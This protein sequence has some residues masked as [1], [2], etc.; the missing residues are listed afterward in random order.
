MAD[1]NLF[2]DVL[3]EVQSGQFDPSSTKPA[4]P[5]IFNETLGEVA[6]AVDRRRNLAVLAGTQAKPD[7]YATH[8]SI[9]EAFGVS[10]EFAA[11]NKAELEPKL[12]QRDLGE[13]LSANPP[14][15]DW[16]SQGDNPAS[17][18]VDELRQLDGLS[19]LWQSAVEAT[20]AGQQ[21]SELARL[22]QLQMN[23]DATPEQ[24]EQANQISIGREPRSFGADNWLQKGWVGAFQQAPLLAGSVVQGVRR[25]LE[26]GTAA[27]GVAA[28]AGQA[29]PQIAAPEELATVPGAYAGGF[30]VGTTFGA[31]E[32][33]FA[34]EAP[35]AFDEFLMMRDENG[36]PLDEDVARSAAL[37]AGLGSSVLET[38]AD[39]TLAKLIPGVDRLFGGTSRDAVKAALLQPT[40]RTALK[41]FATN[42]LKAGATEIT[43]EVAQEA[44]QIFVGEI[45]KQYA[46]TTGAE[47][48]AMEPDDIAARLGDAAV[49]TAQAMTI[50]GP[51]LAGT[52]LGV[53]LRRARE[54][55][56]S[57]Q[58]MEGLTAHAQGNQEALKRIPDK[59]RDAVATLTKDGPVQ[60]VY[61]SPEAFSTYFQTTEELST[62]MEEVGL[63][64]E[65]G[66][67][68]RL[69]RDIQIPVDLYYTKIAGSE[70]GEAV[71]KFARISQ[72]VMTSVEAD[73]FNEAW[74]EA[75]EALFAEYDATQQSERAA[76]E[77]E[78]RVFDDVKSKAMAAGITPDQAQQYAKLYSTFFRV[79]GERASIDP[80]ELFNRYGF[81]IKR[82]LP[83]ET[84]YRPINQTALDLAVI[85][86]GKVEGMRKKVAKAGGPSL[87]AAIKDVGGIEDVGGDLAAMDFPKRLIK[88]R[89]GTGDMLGGANEN[90]AHPDA[91]AKR[92]WERGYFAGRQD[93]PGGKDLLD[94]IQAELAGDPMFSFEHDR[95]GDA[96]IQAQAGLVAFADALD[97]YGIDVNSMTDEEVQAELDKITNADPSTGALF[98]FAGK[99]ARSIDNAMLTKAMEMLGPDNPNPRDPDEVF[100]ETGFFK[101]PDGKWRFEI[102]DADATLRT[103]ER[104]Q[105]GVGLRPIGN[106]KRAFFIGALGDILRHSHLEAAYPD[107]FEGINVNM[108]V[109]PI[110]TNRGSYMSGAEAITVNAKTAEEA[111]SILLHEVA[112]AIQAKES[113][114]NGGNLSMGELYEGEK[115]EAQKKLVERLDAQV[116]AAYSE[117]EEPEPSGPDAAAERERKLAL[118][119]S[120]GD[121]LY[122]AKQQLT[123][124]AQYEYYRRIAGEVEARNV[125]ERDKL[126][127]SDSESVRELGRDAPW[128]TQDVD[129]DQVII[130]RSDTH[131]EAFAALS[132][133]PAMTE[134]YQEVGVA[135]VAGKKS[136]KRGSIQFGEGVTIINMFDQA[137]LSTFLHE[138]GHFF[139][140]VFA[141]IANSDQADMAL[142]SDWAS[143]VEYLGVDE[144][145][146]IGVEA[147]EKFARSFEAYLFEGK[148]PSAELTDIMTRFRSWLVFVYKQVQALR[149]PIDDNIRGVMSRMLATDAE[150]KSMQTAPEFRPAFKSATDAG[151]TPEQWERYNVSAAKA[152]DRAKRELDV[153]M[154]AEVQRETSAEYRAAKTE[155]RKAVKAEYEAIPAYRV[156]A[157]LRTG[158]LDG[159]PEG[160]PA[161]KLDRA[162]IVKMMGEGALIRMP[163]GV[164]PLYRAEGGV[165]PDAIAELFGFKSGH[166]MLTA[167]MS[168]PN[169]GR[170]ITEEVS[171]RMRARFGDLMG[172]ANAR[173]REAEAA[174]AND[175]TGEL[176]QA[177]LEVLV[178]KGLVNTK[179]NKEAASRAAKRAIRAKP[180]REAIRLKLY[181]NANAKA[182]AEAEKAIL[183]GD[184][185]TAIAAKQR[186]LLNHYMAIEARE[187]QRVSDQ[188]V[189]YL[190]KFTGKKRPKGLAVDY[191]EQIDGLLERFDLRKSVGPAA[192]QRRIALSEWIAAQEAQ[193]LLVS[194]PD[195][196][197]NDAMRKPFRE[198][199]V[200]DLLALT[201]TVK[202]IE[203]LGRLKDKLLANKAAREFDAVRNEV[204]ASIM[205]N[206]ELGRVSP[207]Q[208]PTTGEKLLSTVKSV[209][210]GLLKIEQVLSWLD[211]GD[212]NGALRRHVWQPIAD[213]EAR[214]N[215]MRTTYTGKIFD[216]M[217]GLDKQRLRETLTIGG[218]GNLTRS[219]IMSVALNLGNADNRA[220]LMR[221]GNGKGPWTDADVSAIVQHLNKEEWDAVQNIWDTINELW[222]EIAALQKRLS[223]VAPPKVEAATVE[224]PYGTLKGG[225]YPVVYDPRRSAIV[226]DRAAEAASKLFE[227]TYLK[228][229]TAHGFT[230]ER[231]KGDGNPL[232]L[233]ID[234]AASH[235]IAVIHDLT[236][237]EAIMD[238]HKIM[239]DRTVRS[240]IEARYGREI[241]QQ[242]VPWLQSIA[243][244]NVK[245]DGLQG[246]ETVM[247]GVRSRATMVGMGFRVTTILTQVAGFSSVMEMVSP[248]YLA[249]G[250]GQ[251]IKSPRALSAQINSMSSE[252][253][254]RGKSLDRDVRDELRRLSG[255]NGLADDAKRFAFHGIAF[256]DRVVTVPAWLGAYT[257]HLA[258]YPGDVEG[259]TAFADQVVRLTSGAGGAKDLAA[260]QR[261]N[262]GTKLITMFY[263]YFSAYYNRQRTWGRAAKKAIQNGTFSDVPSL[264][265]QQVFMTIGPAVLAD[266]IVGQ[267]PGEDEDY[268]SWVAKKVALYPFMAL[269]L[270]R[271]AISAL[272]SGF[273]YTFTPAGRTVQESILDPI[274][275]IAKIAEG[276]ATARETVVQAI[277]TT[278]YVFN[279]PLGQLATTTNNVWKAIEEDDLQLRDFVVSR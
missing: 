106:T 64:A 191:L 195:A 68:S 58:I 56:R 38:F 27:A 75:K 7:E 263:S 1:K 162:S 208:N 16:Y 145:G 45:V 50:M 66:E 144:D 21:T 215:D 62:F 200:D 223:G 87:L 28:I 149:A 207:N 247:R 197:R 105:E 278:G 109:G 193:G 31:W 117:L 259:A 196:L 73:E 48:A 170:A 123:Y 214:E 180:I 220:K 134:F 245:N 221:G 165:H 185:K 137:D 114:A 25:G 120:L 234:L 104:G 9:A 85:R 10:T 13:L 90:L 86:S 146:K 150:I 205:V 176:L 171:I 271:D 94:A 63:T 40:I 79:M 140:Q 55:T 115:V 276:E 122:N 173:V 154:M 107:L 67:A 84:Q 238:A 201:D 100:K 160:T 265:A 194:I 2:D 261:Q 157:Y 177:E 42:T 97:Q 187:A 248:R 272:D 52:R 224:T 152:V 188:A 14:L 36:Q 135:P 186:Q 164:P 113:F 126:V 95:R 155:I 69:G 83:E 226:E 129:P 233:N 92:L 147:H 22:R 161:Y 59:V 251:F 184:W 132:D 119:I 78:E 20:Q 39:V 169:L 270:V 206:Q 244:D 153:K 53:D 44:T 32:A 198:M 203:H 102:S 23:G 80:A 133:T 175:D 60:N 121:E 57:I 204:L 19:W 61:V 29:G 4:R 11:R 96:E 181:M 33:S 128:W 166:D 70:I 228:P 43:T 91:V 54:A 202:S 26:F 6:G 131:G 24:I 41:D 256:M 239:T 111:R 252:M 216:I 274:K 35:L 262:E 8:K 230:K 34:T 168:A 72:D 273:G 30:L 12:A 260:I 254:H 257:Q 212:I 65:Y 141:D 255:K 125:Q 225:Y 99:R 93:Q 209:D 51:V 98:Q 211:G 183:K 172:D 127:R 136:V 148:T 174:I 142:A 103:V 18:K 192:A 242:F 210:A 143:L 279:L 158:K 47:F 163:K 76:L 231:T 264:L 110:E 138:S 3:G 213:A 37:I 156:L 124:F 235:I 218:I 74:G 178:R 246:I 189:A 222:P 236:H 151:M 139:L 17:I 269:P 130:V 258:T 179:L 227:N 229:A 77:G 81:D 190:S 82:A 49:Q 71:K 101:G 116:E 219:D 167:I 46:N 241:Y 217:G 159:L 268:A 88:T 266:L 199:T 250:L 182:A 112:H 243:H 232:Q 237:R 249:T 253:R 240:E 108:N 118:A 275:L 89:D 15:A 277:T 5:S 267:G